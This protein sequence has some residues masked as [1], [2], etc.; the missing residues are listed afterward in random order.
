MFAGMRAMVYPAGAE[1][2]NDAMPG[3]KANP[4]LQVP[5]TRL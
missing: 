2:R 5:K 4:E 3:H 1:A